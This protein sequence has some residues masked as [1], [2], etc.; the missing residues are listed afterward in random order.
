MIIAG[1][2]LSKRL[3][4]LKFSQTSLVLNPLRLPQHQR[5]LHLSRILSN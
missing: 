3:E 2:M 1:N 5:S 4:L